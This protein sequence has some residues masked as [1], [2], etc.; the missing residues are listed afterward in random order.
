M[1][2]SIDFSKIPDQEKAK[3]LKQNMHNK[4]KKTLEE[5]EL[6]EELD[7]NY[8]YFRFWD[9]N[10]LCAVSFGYKEIDGEIKYAVALQSKR[11]CFSRKKARQVIN[12]RW[13]SNYGPVQFAI[14]FNTKDITL[15][16]AIHWN[17]RVVHPTEYQI[18]H[19]PKYL[20][21]IPIYF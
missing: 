17:S 12:K 8:R 19:I 14:P 4:R 6:Q 21:R 15:L 9:N 10:S 7:L 20:S 1:R 3:M 18:Y 11:D 5:K 2:K 13:D 16:I